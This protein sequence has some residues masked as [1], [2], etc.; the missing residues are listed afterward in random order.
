[1]RTRLIELPDSKVANLTI[2][3]RPYARSPALEWPLG[4]GK[5]L[6]EAGVPPSCVR[7]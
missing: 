1:M 3:R 6:R 4:L 2:S 5:T 7:G